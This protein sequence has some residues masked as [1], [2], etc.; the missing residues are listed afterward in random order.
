MAELA[1]TLQHPAERREQLAQITREQV[2]QAAREL[3]DPANLNVVAVGA[4]VKRNREKL[5]KLTLEYT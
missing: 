4:Q 5:Q 1:R 3:F 2:M